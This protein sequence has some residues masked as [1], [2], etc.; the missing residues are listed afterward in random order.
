MALDAEGVPVAGLRGEPMHVNRAL[1]SCYVVLG[2][3]FV[4]G[5]VFFISD[6]KAAF[7]RREVLGGLFGTFFGGVVV[8]GPSVIILAHIWC[9][10]RSPSRIRNLELVQD[11]LLRRDDRGARVFRW[12]QVRSVAVPSKRNLW[13]YDVRIV[14]DT[15]DEIAIPSCIRERAIIVQA[16]G[17]TKRGDPGADRRQTLG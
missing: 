16:I 8:F 1:L 10:L 3:L 5:D 4:L 13:P 11:G 17:E 15:G 7:A 12:E 6:V 9:C 14:F 2:L